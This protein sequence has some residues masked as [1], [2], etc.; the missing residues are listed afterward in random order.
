MQEKRTRAYLALLLVFC[1]ASVTCAM[2]SKQTVQAKQ[3][4]MGDKI[5]ISIWDVGEWFTSFV[6]SEQP[7]ERVLRTLEVTEPL[8]ILELSAY[9]LTL[10][11]R[12]VE[13]ED[14][15]GQ[16]S[17]KVLV[18][19]V[20]INRVL[21]PQFPDTI[22]EVVSQRRQFQVWANGRIWEVEVTAD[23]KQAVQEAL[24]VPSD[25]DGLYFANPNGSDEGWYGWMKRNLTYVC[26]D[27]D[28]KHVFF[29]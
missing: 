11:E 20:I 27:A 3:E 13:A 1:I 24:C 2:L 4:N 22:K 16:Y 18:A 10:L 26:T 12:C 15:V 9:E 28:N 6:V 14:G 23:T 17:S 8:P 21:S 5:S 7:T 29:K 19:R 25:F